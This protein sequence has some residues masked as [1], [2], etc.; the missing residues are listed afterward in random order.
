M[1][2]EGGA[3]ANEESVV[4]DVT[5]IPYSVGFTHRRLLRGGARRHG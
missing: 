1:V 2:L 5:G 3:Y 4:V